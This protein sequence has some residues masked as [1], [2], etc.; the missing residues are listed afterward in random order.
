MRN[1]P[2][3]ATIGASLLAAAETL[4]GVRS[5]L[6]QEKPVTITKSRPALSAIL[7]SNGLRFRT[8]FFVRFMQPPLERFPA[9]ELVRRRAAVRHSTPH[10]NPPVRS[11][12]AFLRK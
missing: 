12:A 2:L 8:R 4:N 11:T 10:D 3:S 6:R 5:K 7:F 9:R 1:F